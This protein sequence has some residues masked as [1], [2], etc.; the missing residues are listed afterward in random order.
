M[1]RQGTGAA[2]SS[3]E[4]AV[5]AVERRGGVIQWAW[6]I[7]RA[8]REE[9]SMTCEPYD[10]PKTL[11]WE[12]WLHVK[13]DQGAAGIVPRRRASRGE[14]GRQP[15]RDLESDEF[16]QLL[17]AAGEGCSDPEEGRW[18]AGYWAFRR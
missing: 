17:S 1:R 14:A 8:T 7:N 5:T 6:G 13:A 15:V 2:R 12:A 9:S 11:V 4:A 16:R 10:I 3:D 18:R